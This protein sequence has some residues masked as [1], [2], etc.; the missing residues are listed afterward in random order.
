MKRRGSG[1]LIPIASLSSDCG[2]G[3]LGPGA[4]AFADFLARAKQNYW[5]VLPL[6]PIDEAYGHSPY[7][8]DSAF[9]YNT[10]LISPERLVEEGWLEAR[11]LDSRP[12]F[13]QGTIDYRAAR[14]FKEKI[15]DQAYRGFN[16]R[17]QKEHGYERFRAD[18]SFWLDDFALFAALKRHFQ[19][20]V[21]GDWED[22]LRDR[23]TKAIAAARQKFLPEIEK[24]IFLQ[25]AF[26]KQW[27][28]L[29]QHC[30]RKGILI[31][32][33]IP[34]YVDY[35]SSDVWVNPDLFKLDER[36]KPYV[37][38][39]VPPDYFSAT[40]QLWGNPLYRWEVLEERDFD[41]WVR[42]IEHNM[43]LFDVMRIDHFR[44]FVGFWEVP[45][46]E[47]TA[48]NG[49]WRE[50]PALDF[51]HRLTRRFPNLSLVAE[52][53]GIITPDVRE[54]MDHF[55]F[56][57]MKVLLF[58]FGED[59]PMHP[60]LPHTYGKNFVV[61][62][63]THDNNTVRGWFDR[64]AGEADKQRLFRYLGREVPREEI[65]WS[66]IRLAM[67]SVANTCIFPMQ[68]LLGLGEDCRMNRPATSRGNWR[69]R[70]SPGQM[71]D[72]LADTLADLT[73]L[74]GRA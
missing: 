12:E 34:V 30:R 9:A 15:L 70:L 59:N 67:M 29:K 22:G 56:P 71:T 50:A 4:C 26:F 44:G 61:Y 32:G 28:A 66:L 36:K 5:Q 49:C 43:G 47:T 37:V 18:N 24:E 41:W 21:W 11:A 51:F 52:D 19:G 74:Y 60:Y 25:Y 65:H 7:H 6:N 35:D 2:I 46:T 57:G 55:E 62:T 72:G 54:V 45:A 69:W 38:A 14:V 48:V 27:F 16:K 13:P 39:G 58:A 3:D 42:R 1:V 53:L 33:D 8:S 10:L 64:E 68:D 23:E 20:R 63:G 17:R 73:E 31:F 40:G